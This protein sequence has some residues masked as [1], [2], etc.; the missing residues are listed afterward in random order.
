MEITRFSGGVGAIRGRA[1]GVTGCVCGH[2]GTVFREG[3]GELWGEFEALEVVT[4]CDHLAF[5]TSGETEH[6]IRRK[7]VGVA[8]YLLVEGFGA[9]KI[10]RGG[11]SPGV[12]WL[13]AASSVGKPMG[14]FSPGAVCVLF[15][16]AEW[17]APQTCF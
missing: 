10:A 6:E 13:G 5:F 17:C 7:A 14:G 11:D 16:R 9:G 15:E 3:G 8:S 12:S 4:I 2:D 1:V